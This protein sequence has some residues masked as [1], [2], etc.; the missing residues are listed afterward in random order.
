MPVYRL[1]ASDRSNGE[2]SRES[3][4]FVDNPLKFLNR[5]KEKFGFSKFYA[6]GRPGGATDWMEEEGALRPSPSRPRGFLVAQRA[7]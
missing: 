7:R 3:P 5:T 4:F 1:P 2:K 6:T